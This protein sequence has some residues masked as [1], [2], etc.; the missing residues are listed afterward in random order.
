MNFDFLIEFS[1]FSTVLTNTYNLH[2][3]HD[4]SKLQYLLHSKSL[5]A[6][7]G[8]GGGGGGGGRGV[9]SNIAALPPLKTIIC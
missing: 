4:P 2:N 8:G 5:N 6:F 3:Y 7:R 1:T 9:A